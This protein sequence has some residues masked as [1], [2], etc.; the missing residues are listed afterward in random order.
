MFSTLKLKDLPE[1]HVQ[2]LREPTSSR[3]KIWVVEENGVRA[4]IKDFSCQRFFIRH[5]VG[6]FLVWRER[7]AY[8]KLKNVPGVP[9]LYRTIDGISV[10]IE[11][12]PGRSLENLERGMTLPE[13]FFDAL[14]KLLDRV[15]R[16]GVAHCD[17][18]RAANVLLGDD[19]LPCLIDWGASISKTEF[20]FYPL[21]LIYRR[22]LLD[23]R[24]AVIKLKLRHLPHKV[25]PADRAR[26]ENRSLAERSIRAIRDRLRKLG[27]RVA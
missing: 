23:D 26:Y 13:A 24:L 1:K 3:P 4:V 19:G 6:R 20:R 17:L 14:N 5:T 16:R 11:M 27:Q 2:V 25:S 18:K 10:V 9:T 12:V 21:N 8:G 22:F 15:H 7:K